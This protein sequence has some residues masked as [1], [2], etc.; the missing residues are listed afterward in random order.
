M[1]KRIEEY[2]VEK[3]PKLFVNYHKRPI[4]HPMG[5]G[6]CCGNGWFFILNELWERIGPY[7]DE[8][9]VIGQVKQ[10]LGGLRVYKDYPH[11]GPGRMDIRY[12]ISGTEVKSF[13]VCEMCGQPGR[14]RGGDWIFTL[15]EK[16]AAKKSG[17]EL[18]VA[19]E[20]L[21]DE[22]A[23]KLNLRTTCKS[24]RDHVIDFGYNRCICCKAEFTNGKWRAQ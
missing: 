1:D 11:Q 19:S 22:I 12:A 3:Y 20:E 2:W 5:R 16:C 8:D 13:H 4:E 24:E 6:F 14:R 18:W 21:G 15:C 9:L 10:K 17:S 7:E 23:K